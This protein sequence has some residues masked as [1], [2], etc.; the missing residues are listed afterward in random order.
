GTAVIRVTTTDKNK[1]NKRISKKIKVEVVKE[2][3][4]EGIIGKWITTTHTMR[5]IYPFKTRPTVAT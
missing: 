1:K 2:P 3:G 5:A 4:H